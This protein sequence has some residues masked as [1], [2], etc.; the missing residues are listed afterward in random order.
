M[1]I[2]GEKLTHTLSEVFGYDYFLPAQKEVISHI[3]QGKSA[4]AVMPTGSGKSLCYQLPALHL[5]GLTIVVSPM[6][7]LMKDQVMQMQALG[8]QAEMHHSGMSYSQQMEVR[9]KLKAKSVKLLY[10]AP[11]TLTREE[12]LSQFATGDIDLIAIDEAHCISTWG[13]DFRPEYR[14]LRN[15]LDRFPEAVCFALTATATKRVRQD[16]CNLLKIPLENQFIESFNRKN[17]LLTVEPKQNAYP[18]L[19][20]FLASHKSESG[21]IYCFTRKHVDDLADRLQTDGYSVL[22]YHAGLSDLERT[23]IKKLYPG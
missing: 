1:V 11:E 7:S 23:K 13:H 10:V 6:I 4:L 16:I 15:I 22:P 5:P 3:L 21:L 14:L 9:D 17:L 12:F 20:N 19:L 2:S 18:R 8:V